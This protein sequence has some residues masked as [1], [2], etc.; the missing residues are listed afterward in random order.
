LPNTGSEVS[1]VLEVVAALAA[2]LAGLLVWKRK[3]ER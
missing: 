1:T 2:G 3:A